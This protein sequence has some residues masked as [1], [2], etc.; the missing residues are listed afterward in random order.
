MIY[1]YSIQKNIN[2]IKAVSCLVLFMGLVL[3]SQAQTT[4]ERQYID[5]LFAKD[6]EP[7]MRGFS[8]LIKENPENVMALYGMAEAVYE[9]HRILMKKDA[10]RN[11][12]KNFQ[13]HFDMLQESHGYAL[14]AARIFNKLSESEQDKVRKIFSSTNNRIKGEFMREVQQ[15][16]YEIIDNAPYRKNLLILYGSNIYDRIA[17]ADTV[18]ALRETLVLQCNDYL[19]YYP[20]SPFHPRVLS[21]RRELLVEYTKIESLRQFGDRTGKGYEKFCDLIIQQYEKEE[22]EHI[23]PQFYGAEFGFTLE[24][25]QKHPNYQKLQSL[26]KANSMSV[27]QLLCTLNIHLNGCTEENKSLYDQFIRKMAPQDIAYVAVQRMAAPHILQKNWR[28]AFEVFRQYLPLFPNDPRLKQVMALLRDSDGERRLRN[29]GAGVNS[30]HDE[31]SPVLAYDGKTLYFARRNSDTGEDIFMSTFENNRWQPAKR[32]NHEVNTRAHEIPM[33][34][35]IKGNLMFIYGNY[36]QLRDFYFVKQTEPKLG[37]GD[38]YYAEKNWKGW[39]N[40]DAL[41]YPVNTPHYEA[42]LSMTSDGQA[43][44][45]TSDRPG[46]VGGYKPNYP[47][48]QLYYHGAGEFNI[49][50]YVSPKT[51]DG[52]G[53]P[54]NLGTV[55]NTPYAERYPFLHPDGETLY[56]VS[57]GHYGLGGYDIF[58]SKRLRKDSW[59]EWSTPVNIGKTLN[60]PFDDSFYITALGTTA[61][62]VSTQEGSGYGRSDIYEIVVPEKY[63]PEPVSIISG[64]VQDT[65]GKPVETMVRWEEEGNASN[66]GLVE[67][68]KTDGEYIL[69]LKGGKRYVY[70]VEDKEKFGTSITADLTDPNNIKLSDTNLEVSSFKKDGTKKPLPFVMKTLHFDHNSDVIRK[71]SFYDLKRLADMLRRNASVDLRIEGHT[72]NVGADAFNQ[73]LSDRRSKSVR[74]FLIKEGVNASRLV[75]KGFGETRPKTSNDTEAGKQINR[76]VEFFVE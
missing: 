10:Y 31:Y 38:I 66:N 64:V 5:L 27:I 33:S 2:F 44:F 49:D 29:L 54:I 15:A 17:D 55:I 14:K 30:K 61:L 20:D 7:A 28:Q 32:L 62:V 76:R 12:F 68:D 63:R 24:N 23:V 6:Y 65:E 1:Y 40:L 75:A 16:A 42:T 43:L 73:D 67:T 50:I 57:D 71:E 45:F 9:Q 51:K 25:Y 74:N 36:S 35:N 19:N 34:L 52:W 18:D 53:D 3:N 70:H 56:F 72:D 48:E 4:Q 26:A 59:T 39:V 13:L 22:V 60:S 11:K 8:R 69:S 21:Y 46:G 41:K 58:M 47:K 37:K